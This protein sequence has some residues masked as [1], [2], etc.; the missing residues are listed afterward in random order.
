MFKENK[1]V[2]AMIFLICIY[3]GKVIVTKNFDLHYLKN[4]LRINFVYI[5]L[6]LGTDFHK[7]VS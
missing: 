7:Y 5:G 3:D 6:Q 1:N 2:D 4:S